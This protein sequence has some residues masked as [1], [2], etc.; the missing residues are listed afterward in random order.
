MSHII[1]FAEGMRPLSDDYVFAD[2]YEIQEGWLM[3]VDAQTGESELYPPH[4]IK[5]V[6]VDTS[7]GESEA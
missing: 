3:F 1:H 4:A 7:V 6:V 5:R 2:T